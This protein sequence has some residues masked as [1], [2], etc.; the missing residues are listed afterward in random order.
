M[1]SIGS[2][3]VLAFLKANYGTEVTKQEIADA[4]GVSLSTVNGSVTQYKKK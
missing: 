2:E 1:A 4:L 3:K